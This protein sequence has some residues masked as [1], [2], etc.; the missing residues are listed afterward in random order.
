MNYRE[1]LTIFILLLFLA[2]SSYAQIRV[3]DE[4]DQSPI[5][6]AQFIAPAG[7]LV[8]TSNTEGMI[9]TT[10]VNRFA[11]NSDSLVVQHISY[12]NRMMIWKDMK[13]AGNVYLVSRE[14]RIPEITVTNKKE[15][16]V[17]VLEGY[18]RSYQLKD[19]VPEYFA[20]GMVRYFIWNDGK[21]FKCQKDAYRSF[22]NQKVVDAIQ[23]HTVTLS[24]GGLSVPY[25][26][27]QTIPGQFDKDYMTTDSLGKTFIMKENAVVGLI[28]TNEAQKQ[29]QMSIDWIAPAKVKERS[30]FGYQVRIA[31]HNV[32][33]TY[34]AKSRS[35]ASKANLESWRKY[36]QYFF[37]QKNEKRFKNIQRV[38][39]FYVLKS[40]YIP[41]SVMQKERTSSG[42]GLPSS[43]AYTTE[44]WKHLD[45][46]IPPLNSN[47]KKLLGT[48]LTMYD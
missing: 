24:E 22:R 30:L 37:K 34:L 19:S 9:D 2:S 20:D 7:R 32:T 38:S 39:E 17:L 29:V 18:F 15:K 21:R 14:V 31:H 3:M 35:M 41:K 5:P 6:F 27:S 43:Y 25:I 47:I 48:R 1:K 36:Y 4:K 33:E 44:Y 42:W 23:K 13:R 11:K 16:M 46:R 8:G 28:R 10:L 26:E 12:G 45:K 40:Y